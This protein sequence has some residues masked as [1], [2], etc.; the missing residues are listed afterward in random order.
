MVFKRREKR[1]LW[2]I[3]LEFFWPRGGWGRAARYV[4]HRLRRLPDTPDKIARGVW[5]GV[6][7]TFT[8]FYGL[9]FLMSA[10]IAWAMRGN[11]IAALLATFFGNPLTYVPIAIVSLRT[12][13]FLLGEP[14]RPGEIEGAM[15]RFG[16]ATADLWHNFKA[17]FTPE[18][19]EWGRLATFW[20]DVIWPWTVGGIIP[21][22]IA[23]TAMY[24]VVLQ[25][26]RAYQNRR[27]KLLRAKLDKLR[28]KP[29]GEA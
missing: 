1:P 8:P 3:V 26:T 9:H 13:H 21:G 7:V 6:F 22:M 17:L 29:A 25:L 24:M 20:N 5:A 28:K 23:A 15:A 14:Q 10:L 16:G 4:R 18:K 12:G 19:A 11:V 2:R 27:R